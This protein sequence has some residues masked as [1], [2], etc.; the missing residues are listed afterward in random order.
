MARDRGAIR[1]AD[2]TNVL[3]VSQLKRSFSR[4]RPTLSRVSFRSVASANSK[5]PEMST[6]TAMASSAGRRPGARVPS[7]RMVG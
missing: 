7:P 3:A 6:R 2:E 1:R 4:A 5:E